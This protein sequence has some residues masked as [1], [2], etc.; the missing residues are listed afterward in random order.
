MKVS[1]KTK[2]IV[3]FFV[4]ILISTSFCGWLVN[5]RVTNMFE[6][7]MKLTSEQT[8]TEALHNFQTYLKT[9]SIPVDLITRKNEA[10]KLETDGD[11]ETNVKAVQDSLVA[12]LK[13]V[14]NPVRCYYST[15]SKYHMN[16]YLYNDP[17]TGKVKSKKTLDEGVD[18]TSKEWYTKCIDSEKR[19]NIFATFTE[20]Y[21]DE[22]TGSRIMT[23]SQGIEVDSQTIGVTGMDISFITVEDYVQNIQL[24]NTGYVLLVDAAGNILVDDEDNAYIQDTVSDCEF[25]N[26]FL[27]DIEGARAAATDEAP[28]NDMAA[29]SYT[30]KLGADTFYITVLEDQITG[31][32]LI[33]FIDPDVENATNSS[34]LIS[35]ILIAIVVGLIIGVVIA[36]FVAVSFSKAI[37]SVQSATKKL[38][39][40]DF[41]NRIKVTSKDEIGELQENFNQMTDS[42][43]GLIK[44]VEDK[45]ANV[46]KVAGDILEVTDTTKETTK[47]V[48]NAIQ[49]VAAGATEQAQS[50]V[51][52]TNEVDNLAKSLEESREYVEDINQMSKDANELSSKG[53]NV[54]GELI[55]KSDMTRENS[56]KSGSMINEML[57]SIKKINYIS[58]AIAGIT[59]QTNLL[60]LNASIEAARAGEAGKGF[61]VVADEIR[62]LAE[63]SKSSTDEIKSIIVEISNKS[64]LVSTNLEESNTLQLEQQ[65]AI[66]GTREIFQKISDAVDNLITG[67]DKIGRLNENMAQNKDTVVNSME[68]IASIS[69][70]SAVAAE[71]VTAS[72]ELVNSTMEDISEAA[73]MLNSIATELKDTISKFIL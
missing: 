2:L 70:E 6:S 16:A 10:K 73:N 57:D 48:S 58:D 36:F 65:K 9:L 11:F 18:H 44:D 37:K 21:V 68:N 38:A 14:E 29:Y 59:N 15:A 32:K 50:T 47:Q 39:E 19:K 5:S 34:Q 12:S 72:A 4:V 53:I 64:E 33:G 24:L 60:A 35:A 8:L 49:S 40:G 55:E 66:D 56:Q 62:K 30:E 51:E 71:E 54:V 7:N 69:E 43:S 41:S 61:A 27:I 28:F 63:E 3:Y 23:V 13:V 31:W 22:E 45:F 25:W 26:S 17:E 46:F 67:L 52:A 1:I 42:V 20:P